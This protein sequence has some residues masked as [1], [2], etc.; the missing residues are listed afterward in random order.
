M[1][2]VVFRT[3]TSLLIGTGHV[4]RCLTLANALK[5]KGVECVFICRAHDGNLIDFISDNGFVVKTLPIGEKTSA[6]SYAGWLGVTWEEDAAQTLLAMRGLA[7]DWLIVDH[8]ALDAR[9]E[10]L[11]R[12][13]CEKLM[14]IDDLADR[15]HDC[16]LLLDQNLGR[17]SADYTDIIPVNCRL[18]VGPRFA[19]LRPEFAETRAYSLARRVNPQLK[20]LLITM[21]GVD[22]NN[23]TGAVLK[24]LTK[25]TLPEDLQITVVMGP[26]APWLSDVQSVAKDMPWET[27]IKVSAK[28]MAQLMADSDLAIGAAGSTSWER[29]CL[30]LPSLMLVLADNQSAI[31]QA[32]Q[33]HGAAIRIGIGADDALHIPSN[34]ALAD[35]GHAASLLV[36]GQGTTHILEAMQRAS[37]TPTT[38]VRP[39]TRTDL[40][41][42]LEW[43]NHP[44]VRPFM[45]TTAE[46]TPEE[47]SA[48]FAKTSADPKVHLLIF[49]I[50][51]QP[52]GFVS[53]REDTNPEIAEWGFYM[54][55]NAPRGNGRLFGQTAL[56]YAFE[57]L[58]FQKVCGEALAG[59]TRSIKFHER[60]G[61][62]RER[63]TKNRHFDGEKHHDVAYYGLVKHDWAALR[64]ERGTD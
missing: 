58:G 19:L 1:K 60:L 36:D 2:T 22:Q 30:G 44:D 33:D 42:I 32:L 26:H 53:F 54:A 40:N 51:G 49:E 25:C 50:N 64:D 10:T 47:H 13:Q 55:P 14:V 7:V 57:A 63:V 11:M 15:P 18:F 39:M 31:A 12:P 20:T 61:F 3:D 37:E 62:N 6:G 9:W 48:W 5:A 38:Q 21:G 45:Y 56:A 4:M 16:D 46:I 41:R 28:D 59:N 29:C 24:A 34:T 8:Y 52:L 35:I 43:R 27:D 17:S 23:A